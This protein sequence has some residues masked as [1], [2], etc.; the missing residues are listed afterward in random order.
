MKRPVFIARGTVALGAGLILAS[1]MAVQAGTTVGA[2][3]H[4]AYGANIGWVEARGDVAHGA[5]LGQSY[6]TGYLWAANVGWIGIGN[7]PS[8]GW[9]YGN[10]SGS[11]WGVNHDGAGNLAG[12]AYGA[13]VGWVVFEQAF[14]KP[15]IDLQCGKLSGFAWGANIGWI[16]L[17]NASAHVQTDVLATG[18]DADGDGLPDDWE[19]RRAGGLAALGGRPADRDGDG[20]P[21]V[22]EYGADTDPLDG[23]DALAIIA[24]SR[25]GLTSLVTWRVTPTRHYRL[26]EASSLTAGSPWG[27]SGYGLILPGA[28]PELTRALTSTNPAAFYRVEAVRPLSP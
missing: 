24:H 13:N 15:K 5:S 26:L 12:Y 7:G 19:F 21:D 6:C 22:D 27:D 8:N 3:N 10:S 16:S 9:H 25:S 20:V 18:P 17:S 11:D 14:G 1:G 28:A 2:T 23:S 4:L